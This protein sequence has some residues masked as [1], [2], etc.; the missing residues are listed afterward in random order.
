[1][2]QVFE[3]VHLIHEGVG[4]LGGVGHE[5]PFLVDDFQRKAFASLL[6][7]TQLH[8][9]KIAA[10]FER[11]F[12]CS[13]RSQHRGDVVL[14]LRTTNVDARFMQILEDEGDVGVCGSA[15]D[16]SR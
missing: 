5:E 11:A 9:R 2:L 16:Q 3:D 12:K 1:M 13:I 4:P 6:V 10:E 15:G 8:S 7:N 14:R